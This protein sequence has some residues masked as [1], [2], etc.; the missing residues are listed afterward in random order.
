MG[1]CW[2]NP[3]TWFKIDSL[4]TPGVVINFFVCEKLRF[5]LFEQMVFMF[6]V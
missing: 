4:E 3:K 5:V 6:R 2:E 1:F